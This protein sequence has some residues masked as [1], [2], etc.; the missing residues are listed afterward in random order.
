[1]AS[2]VSTTILSGQITP[3]CPWLMNLERKLRFLLEKRRER[4]DPQSTIFKLT[5]S[6]LILD[7]PIKRFGI[8]RVPLFLITLLKTNHCIGKT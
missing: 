8:K 3:T 7:K 1:M 2:S 6:L 5:L 4:Q